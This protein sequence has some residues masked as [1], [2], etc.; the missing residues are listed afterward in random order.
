[1]KIAQHSVVT[2]NYTLKNSKGELLDTSEG[3]EPLVYLHGVGGLIPGL[4]KE[5]DDKVTGDKFTAVIPPEEAYG[6]RREELLK[7][8]SKDGFQGDEEIQVGMQVQLQ[9]EHGPAIAVIT[10]IDGNDVTLDLNHPLADMTLHFD[11]AVEDVREA[12]EEEI[13]HGHVHGPGGHQH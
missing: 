7:L 11:V 4:E 12:T 3:R 8:V 6:T 9:T 10:K 1:M 2:L 13:A 5:L